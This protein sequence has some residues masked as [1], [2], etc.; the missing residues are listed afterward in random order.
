VREGREE[1]EGE[2]ARKG[3]EDD[4]GRSSTGREVDETSREV[5]YV[6]KCLSGCRVERD[7][8]EKEE[9]GERVKIDGNKTRLLVSK[10]RNGF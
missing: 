1:G 4:E 6:L 9:K 5:L 3:R 7:W 2:R 8:R 10:Y